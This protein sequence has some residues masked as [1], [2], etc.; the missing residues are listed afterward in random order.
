MAFELPAARTECGFNKHSA[1]VGS[2]DLPDLWTEYWTS[3]FSPCRFESIAPPLHNVGVEVAKFGG[4]AYD[5]APA[6]AFDAM[7]SA[8]RRS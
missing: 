3:K 8:F 2:C 4:T 1:V 5:K 7:V 6:F